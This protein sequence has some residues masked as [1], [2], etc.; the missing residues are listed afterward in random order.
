MKKDIINKIRSFNRFYTKVLGVLNNHYLD[1][2]FKLSEIRIIQDIY[3]HPDRTAKEISK[4]LNMDKGLLS[5]LLKKLEQENYISKCNSKKDNRLE[6]LSLSEKGLDIY[7]KLDNAANISV[8]NIFKD[9]DENRLRKIAACM[10]YIH[11]ILISPNESNNLADLQPVIVRLI[12]KE[13]DREVAKL[14]RDSVE[15][16]GA[17][18]VG[19]FYDDPHTDEMYETFQGENAEYWVIESAGKILGAGGFYPTKGLPTGY[20]ELSKFHFKPELRGKGLGKYLLNLIENRATKKGYTHMYLVSYVEFANAVAMYE[21][22]GYEHIE[23][24]LDESGL[25][26]GAPFHMVKNLEKKSKKL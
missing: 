10:E 17:P 25:Y 9:L 15:E 26:Q 2:N 8:E 7:S 6:I 3:L 13:D 16:H 14:L 21:K 18:R 1:T 23:H 19:T 20:A 24:A 5:R 22:C 12:E 11:H 4:E